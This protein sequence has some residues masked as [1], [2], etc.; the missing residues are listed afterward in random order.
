M[1]SP[2]SKQ[3]QPPTRASSG[4]WPKKKGK[5]QKKMMCICV[6]W[7]ANFFRRK[8]FGIWLGTWTVWLDT[9]LFIDSSFCT[10]QQT[11]T[12]ST[13]DSSICTSELHSARPTSA[14]YSTVVVGVN[15]SRNRLYGYVTTLNL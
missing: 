2:P 6:L 4:H 11:K 3:P 1:T 5:K 9:L 13:C 14:S 10:C 7:V 12:N 8:G 15:F